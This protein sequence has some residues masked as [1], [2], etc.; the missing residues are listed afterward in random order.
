MLR[1]PHA[2]LI[3]RSHVPPMG[4]R[5]FDVGQWQGKLT[6]FSLIRL[7]ANPATVK[8]AGVLV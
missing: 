4:N 3:I 7:E 2:I 1:R 8:A 5:R 6:V